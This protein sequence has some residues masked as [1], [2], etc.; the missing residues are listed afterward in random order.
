[1]ADLFQSEYD[2]GSLR[3][4]V[5]DGETLW[6]L[7][8]VDGTVT[9]VADPGEAEIESA[10]SDLEKAHEAQEKRRR[11]GEIGKDPEADKEEQD[12]IDA[13]SR[14]AGFQPQARAEQL[15]AE[16]EDDE[17]NED[18]EGNGRRREAQRQGAAAKSSGR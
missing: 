14:I 16:D 13:L 17:E 18:K 10:R 7:L 5:Q 1:M 11:D 12:K 8:A 3:R 6:N 2:M 9:V 4:G 15:P